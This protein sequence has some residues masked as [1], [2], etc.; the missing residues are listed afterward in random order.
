MCA[1]FYQ[2]KETQKK[3]RVRVSFFTVTAFFSLKQYEFI[4]FDR[5]FLLPELLLLTAAFV[6]FY[7][8]SLFIL[9]KYVGLMPNRCSLL[10]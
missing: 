6:F 8:Y 10:F 2:P 4:L 7:C 3:N 9:H 1:T 5:F